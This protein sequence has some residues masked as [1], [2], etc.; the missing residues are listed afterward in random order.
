MRTY[1]ISQFQDGKVNPFI[2][3]CTLPQRTYCQDT[4]IEC[5]IST[6]ITTPNGQ[7][8][9]EAILYPNPLSTTLQ[10]QIPAPQKGHLALE[11]YNMLG[12]DVGGKIV[13]IAAPGTFEGELNLE[14]LP[15]GVF[16]LQAT[17]HTESG[18]ERL[19]SK[20]IYKVR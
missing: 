6:D 17:L 3:D 20:M 7:A 13:E 11:V 9:E 2:L 19:F 15:K 1:L 12:Q 16:V 4:W 8:K 10:V 14:T 5:L 18:Q